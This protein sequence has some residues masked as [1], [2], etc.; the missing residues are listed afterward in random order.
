MEPR[1][2]CSNVVN[3]KFVE[4]QPQILRLR[5]AQSTRQTALRMTAVFGRELPLQPQRTRL[6]WGTPA[7]LRR[8]RLRQD[9]S[10]LSLKFATEAKAMIQIL[11]NRKRR[12]LHS[13]SLR[14]G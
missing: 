6:E 9:V 3:V 13:A 12:S 7:V 5:L 11:N 4:E 2:S 8:E 1:G 14:S 10:V